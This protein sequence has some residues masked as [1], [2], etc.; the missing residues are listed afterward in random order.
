MSDIQCMI[1]NNDAI[2]FNGNGSINVTG[3]IAY[4]IDVNDLEMINSRQY[5]SCNLT[6]ATSTAADKLTFNDKRGYP[7]GIRTIDGSLAFNL[8][9]SVLSSNET[10]VQNMININHVKTK[11]NQ[12]NLDYEILYLKHK[13]DELKT[14]ILD[15]KNMIPKTINIIHNILHPIIEDFKSKNKKYYYSNKNILDKNDIILNEITYKTTEMIKEFYKQILKNNDNLIDIIDESFFKNIE[16]DDI[17]ILE[18]NQNLCKNLSVRQIQAIPVDKIKK[19]TS[20][21]GNGN[22]L[23]QIILKNGT[24]TQKQ[25]VK[26][27]NGGET[28][29]RQRKYTHHRKMKR[30]K[31][32]MNRNYKKQYTSRI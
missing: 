9:N 30:N 4:K 5:E 3:D 2:T 13:M 7:P 21:F 18:E 25:K 15:K 27:V 19:K 32:T 6:E 31:N 24:D 23:Q 17:H 10:N 20:L 28:I 14:T 12:E 1:I 8:L 11:I 16:D 26:L 22:C 29:K